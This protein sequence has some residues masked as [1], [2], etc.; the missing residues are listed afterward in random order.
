MDLHGVEDSPLMRRE[1]MK[2]LAGYIR[3]ADKILNY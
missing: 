2:Q 3:A 1:G